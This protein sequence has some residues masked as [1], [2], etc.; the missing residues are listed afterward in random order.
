MTLF[1][2]MQKLIWD[3]QLLRREPKSLLKDNGVSMIS[4]LTLRVISGQ[5]K[6]QQTEDGYVLAGHKI[7]QWF[8]EEM[9]S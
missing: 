7:S 9:N 8:Y 3:V 6:S 2:K 1:K 5:T 4:A